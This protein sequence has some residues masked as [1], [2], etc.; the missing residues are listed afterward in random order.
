MKKYFVKLLVLLFIFTN[1]LSTEC[2]GCL[3]FRNAPQIPCEYIITI[4]NCAIECNSLPEDQLDVKLNDEKV[5][6]TTQIMDDS[7]IY[8]FKNSSVKSEDISS[9]VKALQVDIDECR[10]KEFILTGYGK[11][12]NLATRIASKLHGLAN[13][14]K[15]IVFCADSK[16]TDQFSNDGMYLSDRLH[17]CKRGEMPNY[18]SSMIEINMA[19]SLIKRFSVPKCAIGITALVGANLLFKNINKD[20]KVSTIT[21]RVKKI[22]NVIGAVGIA[23]FSFSKKQQGEYFSN[24]E[25]CGRHSVVQS[26][27]FSAASY[28]EWKHLGD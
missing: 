9:L 20:K 11:G 6:K 24:D 3:S 4:H 12:A 15:I 17:F 13:Q 1:F 18:D 27:A 16:I 7:I 10:D 5:G 8:A 23:A 28:N 19:P 14:I 22:A 2:F 25:I 26:R 21:K